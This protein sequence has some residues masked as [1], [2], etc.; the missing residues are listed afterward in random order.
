MGQCIFTGSNK[1]NCF[2]EAADGERA[3]DVQRW[4]E[5]RVA[6]V[7]R[8]RDC[9]IPVDLAEEFRA[10]LDEDLQAS[11]RWLTP[12]LALII[13][14][15]YP[16]DMLRHPELN[17]F[18]L[19]VRV[20]VVAGMA[21]FSW[22]LFHAE[23][24]RFLTL[25]AL[26]VLAV[27]V[28]GQLVILQATGGVVSDYFPLLTA[29]P[30]LIV[31]GMPMLLRHQVILL[32]AVTLV[33]VVA[34]VGMPWAPQVQDELLALNVIVTLSIANVLALAVGVALRRLRMRAFLR[35]V[36]MRDESEAADALL[37]LILPAKVAEQL[38][39]DGVVPPTMHEA[40][41][42]L[43]TDFVGFTKIAEKMPEVQL[44]HEL[45]EVFTEFDRISHRYGIERIKT[46]GDAYMAVAGINGEADHAEAAV[47]AAEDMITYLKRRNK[48]KPDMPQWHIRAGCHSGP[49]VSG[50]IGG[51]RLAFDVWG[52][53]VNVAARMEATSE[54]GQINVSSRT[55]ALLPE[56]TST[57]R[58]RLAAK[59]KGDLTMF[60][61]RG[62]GADRT[63]E[64]LH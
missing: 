22:P 3:W 64:T 4:L 44:I 11:L 36:Q 57:H 25:H 52:D 31:A 5:D 40:V 6:F 19:T 27:P 8:D 12:V 42:I 16:L 2:T 15:C 21:A 30:F 48:A 17:G 14:F 49:V 60:F 54:P 41:T 32:L 59:N 38:L 1:P 29:F 28:L 24:P 46:I 33:S 20:G 56:V 61:V 58:G 18:L 26:G 45:D 34:L 39:N 47:A 9:R 55:R 53:T 7:T 51:A 43:F 13:L 10:D 63:V 35:G 50:V 37:K 62:R 23:R